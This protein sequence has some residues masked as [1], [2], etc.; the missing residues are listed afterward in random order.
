LE[1]LDSAT[2]TEFARDE[3][4]EYIVDTIDDDITESEFFISVEV[5]AADA[6]FEDIVEF[7][8]AR[9]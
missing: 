1:I 6:E 8:C 3:D 4:T 9:L 2:D 5:S 7:I